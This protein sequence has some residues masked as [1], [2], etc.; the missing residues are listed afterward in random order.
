MQPVLRHFI[1]TKG[2]AGFTWRAGEI[3]R[4]EAFSDAVFAF[5]VTLLVVSLEVPHNFHDLISVMKGFP[6]FAICF[7]LLAQVWYEHSL[8]FQRYGLQ[9]TYSVFL[10]CVLL[11]VVL[12]YVYPLKFLFTVLVGQITHGALMPGDEARAALV[13]DASEARAL[14]IIYGLGFAAVFCVFSLLYLYAYRKRQA[15]ELN[16]LEC[17]RTRHSLMNNVAMMS[18]GLGSALLALV[19]PAGLSGLA[20]F[21]YF[22]IGFYHWIAGTIMGKKEKIILARMESA[23]PVAR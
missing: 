9:D 10:N 13:Q 15:L 8:F 4:L 17:H 6:A 1:A 2:E 11:F 5:A 7:A 14:L 20:G 23:A 21:L 16:E 12:F 18:F 19:L 3:S 22:G